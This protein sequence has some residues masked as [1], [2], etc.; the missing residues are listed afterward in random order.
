M[1]R[2]SVAPT[3]PLPEPSQR[4]TK[5]YLTKEELKHFEEI[6]LQKRAEVLRDLEIM[7]ASLQEENNSE[8]INSSYSMHMADHGTETLDREQRFMFIARDERYLSYIDKALERIKN[9]TYGICVKSGLPIPKERL[10]AVPHTAVRIEYK[11]R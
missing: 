2:K 4:L 1:E 9:G 10:E 6:L 11:N 7:R 5:T 3:E 8:D